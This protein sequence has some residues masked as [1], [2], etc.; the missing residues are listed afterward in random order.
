LNTHKIINFLLIVSLL[1]IISCGKQKDHFAAK[2]YHN[3]TSFFNGYYNARDLFNK[4]VNQLEASYKIPEEGLIDIAYLGTEDE[5]KGY[6]GD[7][8]KVIEKNDVVMYKHPKGNWVDDCR[9]LNGK[10]WFYKQNYTLA[11][12]NFDYVVDS[13]PNSKILP[14]VHFWRA[15]TYYITDQTQLSADVLNQFVIPY[16]QAEEQEAYVASNETQ[17]SIKIKDDLR[18]EF[19]IFSSKVY[20]DQEDYLAAATILEQGV[21][22]IK[23]R[24]RRIKA[25]FL[26]G[27]LYDKLGSFP[28]SFEYFEKVAK[29]N[30]EYSLVFK[31]KMRVARLYVT[32]QRVD[33]Q[34]NEEIYKY[35]TKLLKDEKNE[36]YRDQ[37][38]YEFALIE[39]KKDSLDKAI[40]YLNQ[41]IAANQGN[42]RQKALSYYKIGNIYF[43]KL[44]DYTLA[45]TYYDSAAA[46]VA[47]TD[48]EYQ[49][50]KTIAS[51]LK[52]YITQ[53]N[54]IQY[55]DSMLWLSTL[56]KDEI[57]EIIANIVAEKKRKEEE[58]QAKLVNQLDQNPNAFNPFNNQFNNQNRNNNNNSNNTGVWY[59]DNPATISNGKIEFQQ[60]WGQR[61]NEDNWRRSRKAATFANNTST[62]S[63]EDPKAQDPAKAQVDSAL[64][65]K[66]GNNYEYYKDIPISKEEKD[67][68]NS[69]IEVAMYKLGQIYAQKLNEPDSA[70]KVYEALLDRFEDTEYTLRTHYALYKLYSEKDNPIANIHK[71]YILNE[72]PR[73]TYSALIQGLDP[74]DLKEDQK[75][76]E[77]TY[78]GLLNAYERREFETCIGF[79]SFLISEFESSIDLDLAQV[80]FIRGMAFGFLRDYDS[81]RS[82]FMYVKETFPESGTIP[83]INDILKALDQEMPLNPDAISKVPDKTKPTKPTKVKVKQEDSSANIPTSDTK[84]N[85]AKDEPSES[86]EE[87]YKGFKETPKANDKI[88]ALVF[89]NKSNVKKT[90]VE[91]QIS[92]VNNQLFKELRLAVNTFNYQQTHLLFYISFFPDEEQAKKYVRMAEKDEGLSKQLT[93]PKDRVIYISLSNFKVAYGQKRMDDYIK[94]FDNVLTK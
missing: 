19:A 1:S 35:L 6:V 56:E 83:R 46:A 51:T 64:L 87:T 81:L 14:E 52:D 68:Y 74:D 58:E 38:Y 7:L 93:D 72:H 24:E 90:E 66:Y 67:D 65:K 57:D 16:L 84:P 63:T 54:T 69:Q 76:L 33:D 41:S 3:T 2:A 27:Q 18:G 10:A 88:V 13:F 85:Q 91:A 36:E 30:S 31:A 61:K 80:Y 44:Q 71:D 8:D 62:P 40:G 70:I 82:N 75:D 55:L 78:Y 29:S 21:D 32:Y 15:R 9:L 86:E 11:M 92:N 50:I 37:I 49:E 17:D 28:K 59:F 22:F 47:P 89:A 53:K 25:Y 79:S 94:F 39:L 77:F 48:P 60:K 5:I 20:L 26:L 23:G 42:T 73:S 12:Q 4:T 43:D 34:G 45:Q